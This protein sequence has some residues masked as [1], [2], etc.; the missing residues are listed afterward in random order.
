MRNILLGAL[1][2]VAGGLLVSACSPQYPTVVKIK[3]T[4][5]PVGDAVDVLG[6]PVRENQSLRFTWTIETHFEEAR[7]LEWVAAGL[8]RQGF[9]VRQR[10]AHS[11]MF[12]KLDVGD[13]YRLNVEVRQGN[14]TRVQVTLT[15]SPE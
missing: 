9:T 8:G 15:A 7:Y 10:Q 13:A 4:T 6:D 1:I 2:V 5:V 3:L 14:P 11:L 12:T